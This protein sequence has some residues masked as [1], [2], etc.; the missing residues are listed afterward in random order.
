M[1][2][3][4]VKWFN[5]AK[6]F[7]F[8]TMDEEAGDIFVHQSSVEPTEHGGLSDGQPVEFEV[9]DGPRGPQAV[10]VKATGPAPARPVRRPGYDGSAFRVPREA[11]ER[12]P[13]GSRRMGR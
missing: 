3:G 10:A 9:G 2:T 6:G 4:T 5:T 1:T 8:I 11:R 13:R 12:D 7:G